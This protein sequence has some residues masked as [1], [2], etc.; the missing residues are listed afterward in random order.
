MIA[1]GFGKP[2]IKKVREALLPH[3]ARESYMIDDGERSHSVLVTELNIER[4]VYLTKMTKGLPNEKNE[5]N[6]SNWTKE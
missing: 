4:T 6:P 5:V 1:N 3:I 2:S